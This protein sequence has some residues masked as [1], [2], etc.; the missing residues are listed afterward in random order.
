MLFSYVSC[1]MHIEGDQFEGT[2]EQAFEEP[3]QSKF[4][5]G[6]CPLTMFITCATLIHFVFI[7]ICFSHVNPKDYLV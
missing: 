1:S 3:K 2:T 5:E 6:K 4:G 7:S